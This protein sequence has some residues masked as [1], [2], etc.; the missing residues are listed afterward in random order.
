MCMIGLNIQSKPLESQE[1]SQATERS[2]QTAPSP[3]QPDEL[4][5]LIAA[6]ADGDRGAFAELYRLTSARLLGTIC[7]MTGDRHLAEEILQ[8]AFLT[9]WQKAGHYSPALGAPIAWMTTLVRHKAIDRLRLVGGSREIAFGADAD[10]EQLLGGTS[11]ANET[12]IVLEQSIMHCL[13][14]LK[15]KQQRLIL[16]A[17][18]NGLTH[19]ELS[20]ET[21]TPLGTVKSD[22]RRGLLDMKVCLEQ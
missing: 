16:L 14:K 13:Q 12:Q 2:R 10:F 7:R 3:E 8:E 11:P 6:T 17:F 18:Y 22:V 20:T 1:M 21:R 9:I 15:E 19:E 5:S 4:A